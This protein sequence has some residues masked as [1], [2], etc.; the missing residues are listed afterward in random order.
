MEQGRE[1]PVV[2]SDPLLAG[3]AAGTA[4]ERG[5]GVGGILGGLVWIIHHLPHR[6]RP[7]V[8]LTEAHVLNRNLR[9]DWPPEVGK[10]EERDC[11]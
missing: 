1:Q 10:R 5:G 4:T 8:H 2:P 3:L 7:Q 11:K 9:R 6:E